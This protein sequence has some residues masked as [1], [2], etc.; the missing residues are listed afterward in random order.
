M[1]IYIGESS[2]QKLQADNR[3]TIK[4]GNEAVAVFD[5]SEQVK[6]IHLVDNKELTLVGDLYYMIEKDHILE[7]KSPDDFNNQIGS[8]LLESGIDAL[9]QNLEG[10]Y[11]GVFRDND[12]IVVFSDKFNKKEIFFIDEKESGFAS[13]NLRTINKF[14]KEKKYDQVS[15]ANLLSV[16]GNYAPKKQTIDQ[17]IERLGVGQRLE[18]SG[19]LLSLKNKEFKS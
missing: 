16:Y 14:L 5:E 3:R 10:S 4:L 6:E 8:M 12:K 19:K 1:D 18:F 13:T 2:I 9:I 15:L 11:V 17:S 7:N